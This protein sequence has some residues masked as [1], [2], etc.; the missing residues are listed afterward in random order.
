MVFIRRYDDSYAAPLARMWNESDAAWPGGFTGGVPFT[1]DRIRDWMRNTNALAVYLAIRDDQVVGYCEVA[2]HYQEPQAA[3]VDLLNVHPAYHGQGIGRRLLQEAVLLCVERGFSRLDLE[4]WAANL[5]AVPL[6]KKTGFFWVPE[7][8]VRMENYLPLILR[9]APDYFAHVD[10]YTHLQRDLS[11]KEDDL[12]YRGIPAFIYRWE[13]DGHALEAVIDRR[14]KSLMALETDDY[15][16]CSRVDGG[17]LLAGTA[18]R[19]VWEIR[20]KART[21]LQVSLAAWGEPGL[22]LHKEASLSVMESATLED[23]LL[24][25]RDFPERGEDEP[26]PRVTTALAINGRLFTL[27]AGAPV[28]QPVGITGEPQHLWLVAGVEG[29]LRLRLHNRFSRPMS[30][31]LHLAP[32]PGLAVE[33]RFISIDLPAEGYAGAEIAAYAARP[34]VHDLWAQVAW[35]GGQTGNKRLFVAAPAP[36][37]AVGYLG[38]DRA[39]LENDS[40]QVVIPFK[41]NRLLLRHKP[42]GQEAVRQSATLGPPFEPSE[43][44]TKRFTARLEGEEGRA[45]VVL[46][47]PSDRFPG[48][49]FEREVTLGGAPLVTCRYGAVNTSGQEQRVELVLRHRSWWEGCQVAIPAA[50]GLVIDDALDFPDWSDAGKD[51]RSLSETWVAYRRDDLTIGLLWQDARENRLGRWQRLPWLTFALPPVP[52]HGR[53]VSRPFYLYIGPGD[54]PEVRRYWRD[55]IAPASPLGA[56]QPRRALLAQP[57]ERPLLV[58][59]GVGQATLRLDSLRLRP[60][61][62]TVRLEVPAGWA[63]HPS[64]AAFADL[65]RGR[66]WEAPFRIEAIGQDRGPSAAMGRIVVRSEVAEEYFPLPLVALGRRM[67]VS[68]AEVQEAGQ[69]VV[70]IDNGWWRLKVAPRFGATLVAME[71]DGMNHLLSA[72]PEPRPFVW[73]NPWFGGVGPAVLV[74]GEEDPLGD[75]GRLYQEEVDYVLLPSGQGSVPWCGVR[76]ISDLQHRDLRGI[77]LEQEVFTVGGSNVLRLVTRLVNCTTAPRRLACYV[78][79]YLAPGG[80][81][82][83]VVLH[84][85]GGRIS[86]RAASSMWRAPAGSW[87]AVEDPETGLVGLLVSAAEGVGVEAFEMGEAGAFP[88]LACR[89]I[90]MPLAMREL[91]GYLV[92][93]QGME[94]ARCYAAALGVKESV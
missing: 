62:G 49:I 8:N 40:L 48:L 51:P 41:G 46:V 77:R 7:T 70:I 73:F 78:G 16:I 57:L 59:D 90:L 18:G 68:I 83:K 64:E 65:R 56:L 67:P 54:W 93:A 87:A 9:I 42:T 15:A 2:P 12:R 39:V 36:G 30:A 82:D 28:R 6:Y 29:R 26:V 3:Y 55:L 27:E 53:V 10:W 43:F 19:M 13:K 37:T 84:Y 80:R 22:S 60:L 20:N 94:Q 71:R 69:P 66:T 45:K 81:C 24:A 47:A 11:I 79:A 25:E 72:F 1:A 33:P 31:V 58:L 63:V 35:D 75:P 92:L 38:D 5:R 85:S 91:V 86:L 74:P 17:E 61:R 89:F 88:F 32:G 50:E 14:S 76:C 23:E 4:T 44:A 21:P 34:G 52:P